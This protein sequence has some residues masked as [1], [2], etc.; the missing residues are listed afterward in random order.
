MRTQTTKPA[1]AGHDTAFPYTRRDH[2]EDNTSAKGDVL[3]AQAQVRFLR[4]LLEKVIAD[5]LN[6]PA[7]KSGSPI[8]QKGGVSA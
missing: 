2:V 8:P 6:L 5:L 4:L 7:E 3:A 1:A